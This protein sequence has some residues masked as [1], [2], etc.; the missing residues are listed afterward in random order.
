M[1]CVNLRHLVWLMLRNHAGRAKSSAFAAVQKIAFCL[2]S[3][4]V[5]TASVHPRVSALQTVQNCARRK[6]FR[7][8]RHQRSWREK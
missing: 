1:I 7:I 2:L 4:S 6:G 3:I 8:E 5:Q